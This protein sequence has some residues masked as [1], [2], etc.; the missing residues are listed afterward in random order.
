MCVPAAA[1]D[2]GPTVEFGEPLNASTAANTSVETTISD[3]TL[4]IRGEATDPDGISHL[5]IRR[6]YRYHDDTDGRSTDVDRYYATPEASDGTFE[7]RVP[8]GTGTNELNISV[9]DGAGYP[10]KLNAVV[11]AADDTKPTTRRLEASREGE[12]IHIEGW[13]S[14]NVQV[15]SVHAA[16]QE[17]QT[18]TGERDLDQGSVRLDHRVPDPGGENVTVTV[19]DVAG[20]TREVTLPLGEAPTA[21]PTPTER[22]TPTVTATPTATPTATATPGANATSTSAA[23]ATPTTT[24]AA[25]G[26][27]GWGLGRIVATV[28]VLGGGLLLVSSVTGGW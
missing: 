6:T 15:D 25:S 20:N 8:L 10:T 23:T 4:V 3:G 24:P 28:I 22:P 27:G 16:G 7:H 19:R 2:G 21:T 1:D 13:V 18:Q 9:V 5:T 11:H 12:W 26:G 17:I 14:D